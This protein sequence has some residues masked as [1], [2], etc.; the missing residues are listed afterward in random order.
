[1]PRLLV[2]SFLFFLFPTLA[3]PYQPPDVNRIIYPE[4]KPHSREEIELGKLLFFDSR[5]AK[6][7]QRSCATCHNPDTGFSDG[8]SKSPGIRGKLLTRHTPHLYNLAWN[9]VFRWDG[10]MT[11][12]EDQVKYSLRHKSIMSISSGELIKR[13]SRVR[14]YQRSFSIVY[15][16]SGLNEENIIRALSAFVRSIISDNAPFDRFMAGDVTAISDEAKRGWKLFKTKA[17][18]T[19][20]HDGSN[21][22]DESF[23]NIGIADSD[24]GRKR[25][26]KVNDM[27]GAFKTPGL[28]NVAL[29]AP[30]MHNGSEPDLE[31][32]IRF[33]NLGGKRRRYADNLIQPLQL[34]D[35]EIR[36]IIAFL[37]T[38]T[39]APS[40][41]RP[42]I[43]N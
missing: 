42:I 34:S 1:M 4:D 35:R 32:V 29:T 41:K 9:R 24:P 20:C 43:P 17:R 16:G 10:E 2:F 12:I 7:R 3:I 14:V 15:G 11:S 40:I 18:C 25:I 6:D 30:Y 36:D 38:L 28:R 27:Y 5:L 22:T 37:H 23:H 39:S 19:K 13:L 31:S 33:Y 26:N 21:F 8:M